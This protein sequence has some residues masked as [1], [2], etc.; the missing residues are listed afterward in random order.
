MLFAVIYLKEVKMVSYLEAMKRPFANLKK[1]IIG[2]ILNAIPIVN[3]FA[4]GYILKAAKFSMNDDYSMPEWNDWKNLF[5][6][7]F[8]GTLIILV[9]MIP[10]LLIYYVLS[11]LI[12]FEF[13]VAL[14]MLLGVI[15]LYYTP[16]ALLLALKENSYNVVLD[17]KTISRSIFNKNYFVAWIFSALYIMGVSILLSVIPY[18]IGVALSSFITSVTAFTVLSSVYRE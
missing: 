6:I 3:I 7:G 17:I 10:F 4:F 1:L 5:L 18:H 13:G 15:T 14:L 9:Y 12:V 2:V 11:N 16:G 8:I